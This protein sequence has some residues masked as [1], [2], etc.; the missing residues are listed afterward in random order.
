MAHTIKYKTGR[1]QKRAGI[2]WAM[3]IALLF[4]APASAAA[5]NPAEKA[6]MDFK[7][8]NDLY[9]ATTSY[10]LDIQYSV[11][12]SHAGGNLVEQKSGKYLRYQE[13]SYSKV[14]DIETIVNPKRTIV[15]NHEDKFVVITDTKK[16]DLSPLQTDVEKLLGLCSSIQVEDEGSAVRHYTLHFSTDGDPEFSKIEIF[17][18]LGDYS[19]RKM[20][21]YYN[22]EMPLNQ[23]DYY[24]K[25]KKPRLEIVYRSFTPITAASTALFS[26]SAYISENNAVYK[27]KGK[28]AS[29]EIINQLQSVRFKK[30]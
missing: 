5:S 2:F 30:K 20:V 1:L 29:Y 15:V 16:I 23:N 7:K 6:R 18:N 10:S 21:L 8:V 28:A 12:D 4:V 3:M 13:S 14:L 27:G 17:I 24:A 9:T 25:E 22:E 26:E 19:I 11:F